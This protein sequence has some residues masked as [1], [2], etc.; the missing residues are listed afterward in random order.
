MVGHPF[1]FFREVTG[2]LAIGFAERFALL[3]E[4]GDVEWGQIV[5]LGVFQNLAVVIESLLIGLHNGR[6]CP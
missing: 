5:A 3:D 6:D 4:P 2:D 1:G